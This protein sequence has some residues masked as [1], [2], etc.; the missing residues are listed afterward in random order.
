MNGL[1]S[2]AENGRYGLDR[3]FYSSRVSRWCPRT[4]IC[5]G[6]TWGWLLFPDR[7][8]RR[9]ASLQQR[10][11]AL[12]L[13]PDVDPVC[14][15]HIDV[16]GVLNLHAHTENSLHG[17]GRKKTEKHGKWEPHTLGF[18]QAQHASGGAGLGN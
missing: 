5:A 8:Q 17:H 10:S 18:L 3:R 9:P 2:P 16:K 15:V 7:R 1:C 13:G 4:N 14:L 6:G 11:H 12:K